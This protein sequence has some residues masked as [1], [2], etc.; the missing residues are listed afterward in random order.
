MAVVNQTRCT[1]TRTRRTDQASKARLQAALLARLLASLS[2]FAG[3][4][5]ASRASTIASLS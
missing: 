3:L 1:A 2:L 4:A 5:V